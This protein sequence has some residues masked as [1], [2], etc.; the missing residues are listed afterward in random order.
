MSDIKERANEIEGEWLNLETLMDFIKENL[1][2][3]NPDFALDN[4]DFKY[5]DVRI[6][7]RTGS[8]IL[9][10]GTKKTKLLQELE[11]READIQE[12]VK[13]VN[14]SDNCVLQNTDGKGECTCGLDEYLDNKHRKANQVQGDKR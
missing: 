8:A 2:T 4:F 1:M 7:M 9:Q 6:D 3:V 11:A 14:H 10:R 13:W 12:L 5:I